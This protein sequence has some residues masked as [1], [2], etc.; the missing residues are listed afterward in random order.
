MK[1][2]LKKEPKPGIEVGDVPV[3]KISSPEEVLIRVKAVGICG[4]DVHICEWGGGFEHLT[5]YIP[6]LLGH[7]F[8]GELAEVGSQVTGFRP[9][10][11]VTSET[12]LTCGRCVYC[13][14]GKP[15]LCDQR[16]GLGRIGIEKKGAM[17]DY[18]VSHVSLLHKI[19]DGVSYEEAA[20]SEPTAV[21][22]NALEQVK[23]FPTDPVVVLGA[24]PIALTIAQG[25]KAAGAYP[26]VMTGL[27]QDRDRLAMAKSLG[28]D[29]TIDVGKE[30]PVEK[31]KRMTNG[32]GAAV[33]FEVSGSPQAFNQ[34]LELL[35]KGGE[36]AVVG[37]YSTDIS[38]EATRKLVR[39]MK[40]IRGVFGGSRL[41]WERALNLMALGKI[42]LKP[43][44]THHL[45]ITKAEE[46]FQACLE[47]KATKVIL[48]PG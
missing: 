23:I 10:D 29:E 33:A 30:D 21:A 7:E 34:G 5:K 22:L 47:K 3:P 44:I 8:S 40:A 28:V 48:S 36:L 27:A 32:L 2:V 24:G 11:R 38:V 9:G 31:V 15:S 25:A 43:L 20:M 16:L 12:G 6:M 37:I 35:R 18:V 19:P 1:A 14:T 45:P 39:E 42:K 26:V 46:G 4:S 41:S 13:I 17:T